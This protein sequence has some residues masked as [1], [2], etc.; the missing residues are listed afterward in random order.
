ME[1]IIQTYITIGDNNKRTE[2]AHMDISLNDAKCSSQALKDCD[3]VEMYWQRDEAAIRET[4][5]K[6]SSYLT[7]IARNILGNAQDSEE[8][9]NDTYLKAWNPLPTPRPENLAAFLG[10][11]VRNL[12]NNAQQKST[13]QKRLG[14]QFAVSMSELEECVPSSSGS[15]PESEFEAKLLTEKINEWLGTVSAEVGDMF[16]GRY[17]F[18][19]S[20]KTIAA[21]FDVSESK[22][23]VTLHRSR[24]GLK[25]YLEKEG[26]TI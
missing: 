18:M 19:H 6:Y 12:A 10:K 13:R 26:F 4:Q 5:R 16:V 21:N 23:K 15:S 9:V 7:T 2:A 20:V 3:I 25:S 22:V 17:F 8:S 24:L 14:S 1:N 11:I